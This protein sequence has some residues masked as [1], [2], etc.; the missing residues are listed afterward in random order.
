MPEMYVD[1]SWMLLLVRNEWFHVY[2]EHAC[3]LVWLEEAMA[4]GIGSYRIR[5]LI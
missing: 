5:T 2:C 4:I 3:V 1:C